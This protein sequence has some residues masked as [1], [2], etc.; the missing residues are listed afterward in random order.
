MGILSRPGSKPNL[1]EFRRAYENKGLGP[2]KK[3]SSSRG[4]ELQ[5]IGV[6]QCNGFIFHLVMRTCIV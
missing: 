6:D 5:Q 1:N 4:L 2:K 3:N